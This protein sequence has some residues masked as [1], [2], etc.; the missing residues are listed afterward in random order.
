MAELL[1]PGGQVADRI[2]L[3][4]TH[5]GTH[6]VLEHEKTDPQPFR[7]DVTAHTVGSRAGFSD[8][9]N[10]TIDYGE[11]ANGVASIVAGPSL[12]LI[13]TLAEKVAGLALSMG[14]VAVDVTVAKPE[15]PVTNLNEASVSIRRLSALLT[16]PR[17]AASVVVAL[18]SNL[19]DPVE[20]LAVATGRLA[21]ILE[22]MRVSRTMVTAP[23]PTSYNA[24]QPNYVN[25]VVTGMTMLSPLALLAALNELED[26][27]GRV[28]ADRWGPRTL[29]LDLIT[30]RVQGHELRS[31]HPVL[32]LPHP[33]AANRPFVIHPWRELEGN[34]TLGGVPLGNL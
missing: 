32:T 34:A 31:T 17:P 28:R 21:Q 26:R 23:L 27:A 18:G 10:D 25:G 9:V 4:V 3:S 15:A 29:D 5:D 33:E 2:F 22:D 19:G 14:A 16:P 11:L 13:E 12:N 8:R 24:N 20:N 7:V 6:G 30:Y 1:L